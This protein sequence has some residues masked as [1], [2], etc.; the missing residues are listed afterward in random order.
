MRLAIRVVRIVGSVADVI[1]TA[2][3]HDTQ[4]AFLQHALPLRNHQRQQDGERGAFLV[5]V[6]TSSIRPTIL[7]KM[8]KRYVFIRRE[9]YISL[10]KQP[11][12]LL[13]PCEER[14]MFTSRRRDV[15]A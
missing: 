4:R 2:A 12:M 15:L 3:P 7:P 14:R 13:P 1:D 8:T 9:P 10:I 5:K 6:T 11:G